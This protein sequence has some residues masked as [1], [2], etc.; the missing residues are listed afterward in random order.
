MTKIVV[1][2]VVVVEHDLIG[3]IKRSFVFCYNYLF[4]RY[5]INSSS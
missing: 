5:E 2:V 4:M 3:V 1:V